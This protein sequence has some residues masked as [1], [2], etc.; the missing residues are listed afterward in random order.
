MIEILVTTQSYWLFEIILT[1]IAS[2][3]IFP[4]D[5]KCSEVHRFIVGVSFFFFQYQYDLNSP[6]FSD[7]QVFST[8]ICCI[9]L[10]T[11]FHSFLSVRR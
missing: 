11:H 4:V 6:N 2:S 1:L 3:N 10:P 7:V 8:Y 9:L 5:R